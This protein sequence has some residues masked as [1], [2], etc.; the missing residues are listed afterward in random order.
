MWVLQPEETGQ[1]THLNV[2]VSGRVNLHLTL[3]ERVQLSTKKG[4]LAVTGVS[5]WADEPREV[6]LRIRSHVEAG[7]A[8]N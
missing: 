2:A 8:G 4:D 6:V 5:L 7:A 1:G 3:R